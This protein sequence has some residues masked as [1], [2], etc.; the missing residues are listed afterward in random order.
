MKIQ[1]TVVAINVVKENNAGD[2]K[3]CS[4]VDGYEKNVTNSC[5]MK[6]CWNIARKGI[7]KVI[8]WFSNAF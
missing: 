1:T 7:T 8:D 4:W 2:W 6:A 3:D 5:L